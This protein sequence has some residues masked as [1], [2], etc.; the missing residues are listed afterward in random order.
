MRETKNIASRAE[1]D[2]CKP[3]R[4]PSWT[5]EAQE[6]ILT[7]IRNGVPLERAPLAGNVSYA[8]FCTWRRADRQF[9][10]AVEAARAFNREAQ[11]N[12]L[13]RVMS[14]DAATRPL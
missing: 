4:S 11:M 8:Q 9:A 7:A 12:V 10:R 3:T 1:N 2:S 14:S 13:R 5:P 6:R